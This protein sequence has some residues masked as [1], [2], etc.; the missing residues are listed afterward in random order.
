M[1]SRVGQLQDDGQHKQRSTDL[2]HRSEP[3]AMLVPQLSS[4]PDER[5]GRG[6]PSDDRGGQRLESPSQLASID[7]R[8][9]LPYGY[10]TAANELRWALA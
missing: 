2:E 1:V 3:C 7:Q 6:R 5:A 4:T 8:E 10:G 9:P